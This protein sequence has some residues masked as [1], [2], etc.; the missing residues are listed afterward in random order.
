MTFSLCILIQWCILML[1]MW[2]NCVFM[3]CMQICHCWYLGFF[4][5]QI[6]GFEIRQNWR[7]RPKPLNSTRLD[8]QKPAL[9]INLWGLMAYSLFFHMALL[10]TFKNRC[11]CCLCF[12]KIKHHEEDDL[13]AYIGWLFQILRA[14][15]SHWHF[16]SYNIYSLLYI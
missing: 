13:V 4:N 5:L 9:A 7:L 11:L 14:F 6:G 2:I 3:R 15:P 10:A 16:F 1:T 8:E 12:R